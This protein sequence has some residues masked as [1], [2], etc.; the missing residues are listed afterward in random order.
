[1]I[2]NNSPVSE[3]ELHA[4]VDGELPIERREAIEA[5][6]ASHPDD[7]ARVATWRA[8]AHHYLSSTRASRCDQ[9]RRGA[10]CVPRDVS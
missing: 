3:E 4:Y 6:L 10:G 7:S 2:D 8:Q 5:W 9:N 1:M